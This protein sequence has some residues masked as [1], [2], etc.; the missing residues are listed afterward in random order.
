MLGLFVERG[1]TNVLPRLALNC[2]PPALCLLSS[3]DYRCE[4][5]RPADILSEQIIF[6]KSISLTQ[7]QF[8]RPRLV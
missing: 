3:W 5:P 4:P 7:F 1:P 6:W 2:D 8:K